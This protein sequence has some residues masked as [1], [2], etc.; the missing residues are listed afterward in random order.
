MIQTSL[1]P[2]FSSSVS[3]DEGKLVI[4]YY[5]SVNRADCY[6]KCMDRGEE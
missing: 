2:G 1:A 4:D 3:W 5:L 6:I